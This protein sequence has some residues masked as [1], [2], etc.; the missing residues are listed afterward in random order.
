MPLGIKFNNEK[1]SGLN[2]ER[3]RYPGIRR[4]LDH[5]GFGLMVVLLVLISVTLLLVETLLPLEHEFI[6]EIDLANELIT[7]FFILELFFR[8][9]ISNGFRN[10]ISRH[11]IEII[12]IIPMLRVFRLSRVFFL[13]RI[14]RVFSLVALLQR[15]LGIFRTVLAGRLVEYGILVSFMVFAVIFGTI[16]LA[17]FEVSQEGAIKSPTD[18]FW[19]S[20]FSLLEG[21]YGDYPQ[22]FGGK[23]VFVILLLFGMGFFAMLTGTIA[24]VMV[25]KFKENAMF[26]TQ[27]P[28]ELS[29]HIVI[30]G[31]SSKINILIN[32]FSSSPQLEDCDILLV[33]KVAEIE[34]LLAK[35]IRIDRVSILKEDFTHM[36]TLKKANIP[37]AKVAIILSEAGENRSTHDI[38]AR[39][40]LSAL[41]IEKLNPDVHTCAEIYHQEYIDHLK[42]GGV[43]DVVIQGE[44]SGSLLAQA[45][46]QQ[47]FLPFFSDLLDPREGNFLVFISPPPELIGKDIP[48][49]LG[50]L[51]NKSRAILVGVKPKNKELIINPKQHIF[52]ADDEILLI[53]PESPR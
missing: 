31:F 39:T 36:E 20:L 9:L 51:H 21:Q 33:S 1:R 48:M 38:D 18:A 25:E 27:N 35:N 26:K 34:V 2:S 13:L 5:P 7:F 50:H 4:I 49:A 43:D 29:G 46:L 28:E 37:K 45:A 40:M 10:F 44:V 23:I 8:W 22:T 42:M 24:A 19:K 52:S 3:R 11:W 32:I 16:G 47:G 53:S 14:V 12:A 17:Q 6:L 15:R 41:T 30:C